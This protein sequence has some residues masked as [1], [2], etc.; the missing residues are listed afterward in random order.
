M[1][2]PRVKS[3]SEGMSSRRA[4]HR[5]HLVYGSPGGSQGSYVVFGRGRLDPAALRGAFDALR[6]GYST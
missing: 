5:P 3:S 1:A 2:D 4:L 6:A